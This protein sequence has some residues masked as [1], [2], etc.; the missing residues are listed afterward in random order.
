M[1]ENVT[2]NGEVQFNTATNLYTVWDEVYADVLI[3]T[4]YKDLAMKVYNNYLIC[5]GIQ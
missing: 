4:E 2:T 5:L 3:E 1:V